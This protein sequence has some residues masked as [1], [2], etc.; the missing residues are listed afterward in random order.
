MSGAGLKDD[1]TLPR[2]RQVLPLTPE[3]VLILDSFGEG[4]TRASRRAWTWVQTAQRLAWQ[5]GEAEA[6]R[7][8]NAGPV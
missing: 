4:W 7:R 6:V 2:L 5:Y 8:L 3:D 1:W